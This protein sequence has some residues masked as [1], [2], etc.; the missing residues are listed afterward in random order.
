MSVAWQLGIT[1]TGD[2]TLGVGRR[3]LPAAAARRCVWRVDVLPLAFPF[4]LRYSYCAAAVLW[5]PRSQT[6]GE[7][8]RQ[9]TERKT[10]AGLLLVSSAT[11]Y[12]GC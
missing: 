10:A 12:L 6:V 4:L 5:E 11:S 2:S 7:M 1:E 8:R 9:W 3:Q